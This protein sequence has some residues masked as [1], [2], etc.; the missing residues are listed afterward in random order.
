MEKIEEGP[1]RSQ[2]RLEIFYPDQ[3]GCAWG[4]IIPAFQTLE[5]EVESFEAGISKNKDHQKEW[6]LFSWGVRVALSKNS[7]SS[8]FLSLLKLLL[9][10][11]LFS[12]IPFS[13]AFHMQLLTPKPPVHLHV[14]VYCSFFLLI[15][16]L[17]TF[18]LLFLAFYFHQSKKR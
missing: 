11:S 1:C 9:P 12:I 4:A 15:Y 7:S 2:S 14:Y 17:Q 6:E 13:I 3:A 10:C 16:Y 5:Q 18:C 8:L